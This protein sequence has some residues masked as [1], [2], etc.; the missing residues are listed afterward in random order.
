MNSEIQVYEASKNGMEYSDDSNAYRKNGT[1]YSKNTS[2]GNGKSFLSTTESGY[3][4]L[5]NPRGK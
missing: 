3:I 2:T 5:H 1:E 4:D